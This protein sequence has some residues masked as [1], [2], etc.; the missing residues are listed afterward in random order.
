MNA[1]NKF[2]GPR[3]RQVVTFHAG[4]ALQLLADIV[5]E[6]LNAPSKSLRPLRLS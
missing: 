6:T 5:L 2:F 1:M 4:Q 3:H